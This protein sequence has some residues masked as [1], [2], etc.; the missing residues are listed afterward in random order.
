M[1][2]KPKLNTRPSKSRRGFKLFTPG[3]GVISDFGATLAYEVRSFGVLG[4]TRASAGL[5]GVG[6][7]EPDEIRV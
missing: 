1:F 6:G 2:T 3:A 4:R 5:G 7:R